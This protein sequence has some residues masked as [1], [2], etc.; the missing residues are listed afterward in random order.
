MKTV[1]IRKEDV[2]RRWYHIDARDEVLG[3]VAVK[4]ANILMGKEKPTFTPGVDTGD[5][6]LVTS[7]K[8]V[9]VTGRKEGGKMYFRHS[10]WVGSG[11]HEPLAALR[12][13]KPHTLVYLAVKRMLP[14]NTLGDHMLKRLKVYSAAEHPHAAQQPEK[15]QVPSKARRAARKA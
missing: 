11:V 2:K 10:P 1:L 7:A 5:F 8:D 3:K 9:R 15:I 6:V 12:A 13:K 14:K 4:A